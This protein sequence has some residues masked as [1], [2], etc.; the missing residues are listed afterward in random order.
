MDWTKIKRRELLR[1]LVG[2]GSAVTVDYLLYQVFLSAGIVLSG[3]KAASF[4]CGAVVG[5]L[6]NKLWTFE[7]RRFAMDE[8]ARY[9]MLYSISAGIN[10]AIHRVVL[11]LIGIELVAFF[12]ATGISTIINFLGQ[13]FFVFRRKE[14]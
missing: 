3:A 2:G 12:C 13:K 7:S 14:E 5:F 4:F 6:I 8:I 1:F 10:A 11:L 9:G